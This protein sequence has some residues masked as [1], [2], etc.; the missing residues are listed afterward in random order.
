MKGG[1]NGARI[2]LAPQ[3]DWEVNRP[4]E[5]M[6]VLNVYEGIAE[7]Y[8]ASVA[9]VIV[10]SGAL[11]LEM[12]GDIQVEVTTGRG[13]ASQDMTDVE[14]F[15]YMEPRADGFRNYMEKE[16]AVTSEEL[17]LDRAQLLG[18]TPTEMTVLVG[19]LR[20]LALQM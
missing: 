14:G 8:G 1:A 19:G 13:D 12:A 15:E 3:K 20:A 6:R 10:I 11:G 17:M 4:D 9:D 18:L 7:K 16:F 5:L 2:R